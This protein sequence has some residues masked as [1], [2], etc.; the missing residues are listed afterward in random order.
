MNPD[1]KF[2][3]FEEL[4]TSQL[5]AVMQLRNEV[6]VV[7]QNC[8]YQDAD[9]K[10]QISFH[11]TGWDDTA[12]VAYCRVLPPGIS[13]TEASIG[14]VVIAPGYRHF[15]YG[16][17]LMELAVGFTLDRF[18]CKKIT[19]SAQLYLEKFY[20]SIGF[21]KISDPYLEDDIPHIKMQL[22]V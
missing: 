2:N 17:E 15:G 20:E 1:W 11:I 13:Y 6:F 18:N 19:I 21:A 3:S 22:R 5:Y 14:R 8:V 7:E 4:S 12:I 9:N 16:R 10:D